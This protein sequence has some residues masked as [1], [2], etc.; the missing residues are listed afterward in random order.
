MSYNGIGQVSFRGGCIQKCSTAV[1]TKNISMEEFFQFT[2]TFV[3]L[4][5]DSYFELQTDYYYDFLI[6]P[7]KNTNTEIEL[8]L[9]N[10]SNLE[11]SEYQFI[12]SFI[13]PRK[14]EK[15]DSNNYTVILFYDNNL[16]KDRVEIVVNDS[17]TI[18]SNNNPIKKDNV[19]LEDNKVYELKTNNSEMT[20]F[21]IYSEKDESFTAILNY[22]LA[23]IQKVVED[24]GD[25]EE[26]SFFRVRGIFSPLTN[27]FNAIRIKIN[28]STEDYFSS[29]QEEN[30][31]YGRVISLGE[32]SNIY[33][34]TNL[35]GAKD[36]IS[37]ITV[38]DRV[39]IWG[40]YGMLFAINGEELRIGPTGYYELDILPIT[41]IGV[42]AYLQEDGANNDLSSLVNLSD[43]FTIDYQYSI[44]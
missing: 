37:D 4:S 11:D 18:D 26:S 12:K 16:K 35:I 40:N 14:N 42:A 21:W 6:E 5:D 39:G 33:Q 31:S 25:V 27:N 3:C 36:Y 2:D 1:K 29:S 10:Y 15:N 28:R 22:N 24:T 20:N 23:L 8:H 17:L 7:F 41:R 43:D 30:I 38:I 13:L 9:V 44:R 19:N 32:N 34:L